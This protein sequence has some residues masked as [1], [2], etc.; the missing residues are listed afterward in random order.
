MMADKAG[1]RSKSL[2]SKHNQLHVH[3]DDMLATQTRKK[4]KKKKTMQEG[5]SVP[6]KALERR[7]TGDGTGVAETDRKKKK[8]KKL[9]RGGEEAPEA[10]ATVNLQHF[11]T[12]DNSAFAN[13]EV[14]E[15]GFL[16]DDDL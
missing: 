16:V 11:A 15:D 7:E 5:G 1:E 10:G 12:F 3:D 4:N 14:D 8:K 6:A 9:K 13:D 2:K